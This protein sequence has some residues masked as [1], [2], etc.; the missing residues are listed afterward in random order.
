M[1]TEKAIDAFSSLLYALSMQLS[2]LLFFQ[3]IAN[4]LL[5]KIMECITV[6]GE[7][8]VPLVVLLIF[9]WCI[10]RKK[11]FAIASS[12]LSALLVSQTLKAIFR[13]PRPFQAHPDLIAAGR[14]ET[15]TGYSFPS[16]HSTTSGAFYSS[17]AYCLRRTWVTIL[18]ILIIIL[19]PISR[20]Y[21]GVHWPLD[22][23]IG[24][25]IGVLSGI[26]LTRFSLSLYDR[27]K[28]YLIFTFTYGLVATVAAVIVSLLLAFTDIDK[29]AFADLASNA[30]IAGGVMLGFY[31]DRKLIS[32]D[33]SSGSV[34]QKIIRFVIGMVSL[35]AVAMAVSAI[36]LPKEAST[37]LLFFIIGLWSTFIYPLI[38]YAFHLIGRE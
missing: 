20:M 35:V 29:T 16:G 28:S 36:P 34:I 2:I 1:R 10:S 14:V 19:V 11:A 3:R 17:L 8:A 31:L 32:T 7:I 4:P 13:I 30:A 38:A 23:V 22:T 33:A 27:R 15:A 25:L 24:T 9:S 12:L 26:F 5:D 21:L 18:L 37:N 6:L